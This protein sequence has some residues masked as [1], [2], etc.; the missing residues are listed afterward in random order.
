MGRQLLR[1]RQRNTRLTGTKYP[2]TR[3]PV[4]DLAGVAGW[5]DATGPGTGTDPNDASLA[6]AFAATPQ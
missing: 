3:Y 2:A 1:Q 4:V 6:G 5:F